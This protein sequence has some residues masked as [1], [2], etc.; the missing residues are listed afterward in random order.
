MASLS[1]FRTLAIVPL[2]L[3]ALAGC[4]ADSTPAD[5]TVARAQHEKPA[6]PG[7]LLT[8]QKMYL[9]FDVAL[10]GERKFE[11]RVPADAIADTAWRIH[12]S[13]KGEMVLDMPLPG[14]VPPS[15]ASDNSL[16]MLEEGRYIGWMAAPPDD[17]AFLA[18][19]ATGNLDVASNPTYFPVEFTIDDE[20]HHR[21]RDFPSEPFGTTRDQTIKG[22][23][24]AYVSRD[25]TVVCDLKAQICDIVGLLQSGYT[26]GTD[27]VTIAEM[28]SYPGDQGKSSTIGPEMMLPRIGETLGKR[29]A[30]I[31]FPLSGPITTTFS[32]PYRDTYLINLPAREDPAL[33]MTVSVTVSPRPAR[34]LPDSS[35]Q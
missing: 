11:E 7:S 13:V 18:K 12:R 10:E 5:E 8:Q 20:E 21:S 6:N 22:I 29:L 24:K 16:E 2:I 27:V 34:M 33:V 3:A 35:E 30:G 26:D 15:L 17:P 4:G 1:T 25:A 23:G 31:K 14:S 32:E 9:S 28:S 19:M